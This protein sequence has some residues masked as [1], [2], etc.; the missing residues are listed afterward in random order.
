MTFPPGA[1]AVGNGSFPQEQPSWAAGR[2]CALDDFVSQ[3]HLSHTVFCL[4]PCLFCH[5]SQPA[6]GLGLSCTLR[7]FLGNGG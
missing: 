6:H 2:P 4:V 1:L 3:T 7:V 5:K